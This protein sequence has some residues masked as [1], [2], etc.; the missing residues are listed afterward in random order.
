MLIKR[1]QMDRQYVSLYIYNH[2]R[3]YLRLFN[4]QQPIFG[5]A[6]RGHQ[7]IVDIL[8]DAGCDARSPRPDGVTASSLAAQEGHANILK[9]L[10]RGNADINIA[11]DDGATPVYMAARHGCV[12]TLGVLIDA[13]A[14]VSVSMIGE[15]EG[16]SP[17]YIAAQLG[18]TE[19]LHM[20]IRAGANVNASIVTGFSP[21]FVYVSSYWRVSFF[22]PFLPTNLHILSQCKSGGASPRTSRAFECWS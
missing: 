20:L 6:Y 11:R 5:A 8:I 13:G 1:K 7:E 3:Y 18:H 4:Y 15:S 10:V 19:A 12:D 22:F 16:A 21:L 9:S 17:V 14:D 2:H